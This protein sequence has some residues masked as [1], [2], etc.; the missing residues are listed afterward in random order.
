MAEGVLHHAH[1]L[2]RAIDGR[3]TRAVV[4][5]RPAIIGQRTH[6]AEHARSLALDEPDGAVF[7]DPPRLALPD[8]FG[9][10]WRLDRQSSRVAFRPCPAPIR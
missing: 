8:R 9:F 6:P 3:L 4:L 2:P 7:L 5:R 10:L 1:G